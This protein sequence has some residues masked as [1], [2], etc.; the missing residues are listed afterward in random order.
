MG[1]RRLWDEYL[2]RARDFI[3]DGRLD[4]E[5][6][7]YK[8]KIGR[9]LEM[10]RNAV[11]A[12]DSSWVGPVRKAL[13]TNLGSYR[14]HVVLL[15]WFNE[16][17]S[18]ALEAMRVI[19]SDHSMP[20][21]ERIRGF[22]V[23]VPE[24]PTKF[25]GAGTRLREVSILLMALGAEQYPPFKVTEFNKAYRALEHPPPPY[26]ADEGEVYLHAL[27]FLDK[28]VDTARAKGLT[29]PSNLLEAQSVVWKNE[30]KPDPTPINVAS[31]TSSTADSVPEPE[32]LLLEDLAAQLYLTVGFLKEIEALLEDKKQ[33]IFQG[34]PGTGKTYVAQKLA[35]HLAG[36]DERVTLVQ[37]HPSY[38]Y[39][40]F[41][42]GFRPTMNDD[43]QAGFELRGG[44]LLRAAKR[45]R[46]DKDSKHFL[47]LDEINRGNL[48][49]VL[50]ELYF[51]LEYRDKE[52][53]LQY[54]DEP[55]ELPPNL[56]FIGTMNTAD[57]SIA[58]VDLALR[59]RFYF[60][61]FHP[62][63]EPVK[64]VL[65]NW[66]EQKAPGMEWVADVVERA[67]E[68]LETDRHAAIGP[69]YFM[70]DGLDQTAVRRIW[71]HSVLSYIEERLI[72]EGDRLGQ[73]NLDKL[74]G[75]DSAA[76]ARVD[77]VGQ[78]EGVA[79]GEDTGESETK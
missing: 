70:K 56:Y 37:L 55:F 65:R 31:V 78:G 38:A 3:A 59:R 21:D 11:L 14:Q 32:P 17:P 45:A 77:G 35:R 2:D 24:H 69:S 29:R 13:R 7:T 42:Q 50:G 5:E 12:G 16:R 25:R 46:E 75:A 1:E 72:G 64:S 79:D 6:V 73:F 36:S 27:R 76:G 9:S 23:R 53:S 54:S 62:D 47:I 10:A 51:L 26:G 22:L 44:P 49:K 28:L 68:L 48:A 66:L 15:D 58:L 52:I 4:E 71:K 8:L 40:D 43:G 74:R 33:V 61:E 39:E 67:N 57:R 60:V 41:V 18:D 19:W 30:F 34:P 63:D 20:I